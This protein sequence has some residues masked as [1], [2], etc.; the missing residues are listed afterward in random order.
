MERKSK[1]PKLGCGN[2]LIDDSIK[3]KQRV[4]SI[5]KEIKNFM[6][7]VFMFEFQE[8]AGEHF[9]VNTFIL[10]ISWKKIKTFMI[11]IFMLEFQEMAG[12]HLHVNVFIQEVMYLY[13]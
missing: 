5:W 13:T 8:M 7:L 1:M 3:L 12:E 6:I 4:K 2:A 9:Q 10:K 11:I